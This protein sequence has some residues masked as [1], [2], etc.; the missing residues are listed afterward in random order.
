MSNPNQNLRPSPASVAALLVCVISGPGL[1]L[2][3]MQS[4][5][6]TFKDKAGNMVVENLRSWKATLISDGKISFQGAGNP[7]KGTW[8]D[9]G[10]TVTASS[11]EGLAERFQLLKGTAVQDKPGAFRLK[12]AKISGDVVATIEQRS[13]S[14]DRTTTL[15][16][17]SIEY[18][19][20][21][22]T[23]N[24]RGGVDILIKSPSNGQ[25]FTMSGTSADLMTTPLGQTSE[26]PLKSGTVEGPIKLRLDATVKDAAAARGTKQVVVTGTASRL[27]FNDENRTMT[28]SG[29]VHLEGDDS[30]IGGTVDASKA[31]IRLNEKH[32][33][34]EVSF[35]GQPGRST[36]RESGGR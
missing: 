12:Q 17:A 36:L 32:E 13:K 6:I 22:N 5:P 28:L 3:A 26:W 35:E 1:V 4:R 20:D 11:I 29:D 19:A 10:L 24:L 31:V 30:V 33:V 2:G 25:T 27:T 15:K 14:E 8:K 7:L 18:H 9:Q 21:A 34:I 16:C 23:A